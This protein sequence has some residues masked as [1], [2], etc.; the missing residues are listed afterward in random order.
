MKKLILFLMLLVGA[1]ATVSCS[2]DSEPDVPSVP[3]L[4][5]P[6]GGNSKDSY[7]VRY[8]IHVG[9]GIHADGSVSTEHGSMTFHIARGGVLN[10]TFGPVKYGFNAHIGMRLTHDRAGTTDYT[11]KIYVSKNQEPFSLKAS[12]TGKSSNDNLSYKINF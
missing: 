1:L 3:N 9:S 10:E 2:K 6:S 11:M 4:N 12:K 5:K 8:E 7:Y